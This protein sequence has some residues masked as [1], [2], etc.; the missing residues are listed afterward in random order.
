MLRTHQ[1]CILHPCNKLVEP[2]PLNTYMHCRYV[3]PVS[4]FMLFMLT[5]VACD[6]IVSDN[7]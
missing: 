2:P 4:K 3:S 5:T 1:H 6:V 7:R